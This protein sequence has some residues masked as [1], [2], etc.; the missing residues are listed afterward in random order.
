M[1][2]FTAL[3]SLL[4]SVLLLSSCLTVESELDIKNDGSGTLRLSYRI[5]RMVRDIG[6]VDS[7]NT[8]I[9]LP[10]NEEDFR[11]IVDQA[12]GVSLENFTLTSDEEV[13]TID[14]ELQFSDANALSFLLGGSSGDN[15]TFTADETGYTLVQRLYDGLEEPMSEDSKLLLDTFFASDRVSCLVRTESDIKESG[16]GSPGADGR[17]AA[18]E[19]LISGIV[20]SPEPVVFTVR[21]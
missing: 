4:F 12:D 20:Q 18:Y 13:I 5:S 17:S 21:W 2:L 14:A 1:K 15:I 10:V 7:R 16:I 6:R 19:A 9:P 11:R 3:G 8:L